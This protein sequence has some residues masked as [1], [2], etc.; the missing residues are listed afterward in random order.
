MGGEAF[1]LGKAER[2]AELELVITHGGDAHPS[3][4]QWSEDDS[5]G[6]PPVTLLDAAL[7]AQ[8][9]GLSAQTSRFRREVRPGER[10]LQ[11]P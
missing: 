4:D 10:Q 6:R 9:N 1:E 11:R 3:D 5:R 7:H 2:A 8:T